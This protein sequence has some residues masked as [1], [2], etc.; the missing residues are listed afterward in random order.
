MANEILEKMRR[1]RI[2]DMLYRLFQSGQ[3]MCDNPAEIREYAIQPPMVFQEVA[4]AR[5]EPVGGQAPQLDLLAGNTRALAG[6]VQHHCVRHIPAIPSLPPRVQAEIGFLIIE[7][8]TFVEPHAVFEQVVPYDET[9]PRNPVDL[10]ATI[11][12]PA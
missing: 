2:G 3:G 7:E 12:H 6:D 4:P 9:G 1:I 11:T 8:I 10:F 5:V